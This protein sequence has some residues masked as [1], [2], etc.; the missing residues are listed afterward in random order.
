MEVFIKVNESVSQSSIQCKFILSFFRSVLLLHALLLENGLQTS[1]LPE[2]L[3]ISSICFVLILRF[4][5]LLLDI[6]F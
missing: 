4:V 5:L 6:L 2:H 3:I 1:T